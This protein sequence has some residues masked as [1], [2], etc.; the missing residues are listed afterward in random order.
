MVWGWSESAGVLLDCLQVH[1]QGQ[2]LHLDGP[3]CLDMM[4][5]MLMVKVLV[6]MVMVACREQCVSMCPALSTEPIPGST[7]WVIILLLSHTWQS[8]PNLEA[9]PSQM[10]DLEEINTLWNYFTYIVKTQWH[11]R[12]LSALTFYYSNKF[13]YEPFY[14]SSGTSWWVVKS[15]TIW[16]VSILYLF[17]VDKPE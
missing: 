2:L 1:A 17:M 16:G 7:S 14:R 15:I 13:W 12:T 3:V 4:V 11:F 5:V 10:C 6:V 8:A 9:P